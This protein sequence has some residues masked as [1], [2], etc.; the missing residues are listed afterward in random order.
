MT[1]PLSLLVSLLT[2][3]SIF[4]FSDEAENFAQV[5]M[6]ITLPA[7]FAI[8][9]AAGAAMADGGAGGGGG[10]GAADNDANRFEML[11]VSFPDL[12]PGDQAVVR[13]SQ[14]R[15]AFELVVLDPR[16]GLYKGRFAADA[17]KHF[18]PRA[19]RPSMPL[20]REV[21]VLTQ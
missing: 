4:V 1:F 9:M 3:A 12:T 14:C 13:S 5:L 2:E 8:G 10:G 15:A 6:A 21:V 11:G 17:K 7:A 16:S 20:Q 18:V 19:F